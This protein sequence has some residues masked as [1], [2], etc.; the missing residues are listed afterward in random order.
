M[1][2]LFFVVVVS[3]C[4]VECGTHPLEDFAADLRALNVVSHNYAVINCVELGFDE[5]GWWHI[6]AILRLD[7]GVKV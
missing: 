6:K 1:C 5:L 4:R 7:R 2:F 3:T